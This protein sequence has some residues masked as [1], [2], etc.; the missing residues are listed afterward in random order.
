[1]PATKTRDVVLGHLRQGDA[2][3]FAGL[4]LVAVRHFVQHTPVLRI[5]KGRGHGFRRQAGQES[6]AIHFEAGVGYKSRLQIGFG[7]RQ[8]PFAGKHRP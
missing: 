1:M 2:R 4:A 3:P 7:C 6:Q 5:Q 8:G